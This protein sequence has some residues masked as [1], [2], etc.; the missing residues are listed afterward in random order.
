MSTEHA[1]RT[2][3]A[4]EEGEHVAVRIDDFENTTYPKEANPRTI[5]GE[6]TR[7]K[8]D[9]GHSAGE[10]VRSVVI[11]D[12]RDDGVVVDLGDTSLNTMVSGRPTQR[13]YA[14]AWRPRPGKDR[15]LLGRVVD[16]EPIE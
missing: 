16:A 14:K 4:I 6:V 12:P 2:L 8:T 3:N 7:I 5:S 10:I 15:L 11:G 1:W 13:Y 9:V